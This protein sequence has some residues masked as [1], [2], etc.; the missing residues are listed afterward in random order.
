MDSPALVRGVRKEKPH[1]LQTCHRCEHLVEVDAL[2]LHVAFRDQ[3]GFVL[4][5]D[6]GYV[7][8]RLIDPSE[9]NGSGMWRRVDELP[10]TVRLDRHH[11]IEH[12]VAPALMLLCLGKAGR[13]D[14]AG[15][16]QVLL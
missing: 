15:Q 16:E 9:P 14:V 1:G 10:C 11:L 8:L 6:P 5:D 3:P 2:P 12:G 7:F 4:G 13:L